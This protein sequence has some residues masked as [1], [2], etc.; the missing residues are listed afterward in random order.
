[1]LSGV[2]DLPYFQDCWKLVDTIIKSCAF[3]TELCSRRAV[4]ACSGAG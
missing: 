2:I 3:L 4:Q 1:M